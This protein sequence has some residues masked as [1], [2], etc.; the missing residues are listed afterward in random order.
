MIQR[1][2]WNFKYIVLTKI[3]K[4]I[5]NKVT[6][7]A[8]NFIKIESLKYLMIYNRNKSMKYK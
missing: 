5:L 8:K 1:D 4:I 7:G 6:I 2:N 3:T